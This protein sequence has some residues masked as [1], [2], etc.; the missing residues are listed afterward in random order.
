MVEDEGS[1]YESSFDIENL[2]AALERLAFVMGDVEKRYLKKPARV[3][4]SAPARATT[5]PASNT[6]PTNT[7]GVV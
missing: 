6:P 2:A 4:A 5:R 1:R 7:G 3:V